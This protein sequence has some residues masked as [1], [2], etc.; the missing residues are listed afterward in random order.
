MSIQAKIIHRHTH[1]PI[2]PRRRPVLPPTEMAQDQNDDYYFLNPS[3][4]DPKRMKKERDKA[5]EL[6]K[7]QW[8]LDQLNRGVCHYCEQCFTAKELTMDHVVPLAR[9]GSSTK[10]NIVPACLDCNRRKKL[11][12]PAERILK[13]LGKPDH[14]DNE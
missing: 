1:K 2:A 11:E 4:V 3:H 14:A 12:T 6:K 7:S 9:G 13:D 10:G 5:R 8:W